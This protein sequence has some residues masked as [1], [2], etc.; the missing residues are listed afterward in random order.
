MNIYEIEKQ[1]LSGKNFAFKTLSAG[2][3]DSYQDQRFIFDG[4]LLIICTNGTAKIIIDYKNYRIDAKSLI[5][6]LP[7]HICSI[8][9]CSNDLEVKMILVSSD[10]MCHL[11]IT[12][13]FNLLKR[14]AIRPYAKLDDGKLDDLLKIGSLINKYDS[15]DKLDGKIQNTLIYSMILMAAS[16]FGDVPSKPDRAI[17]RQETLVRKFFDLLIDSCE[18]ERSVSYYAGKL[19]VSPKYLSSVVK[20]VSNHSAQNW[21]NE[22]VLISAKRHIMTTDMTVYQ[23]ADKLHFQTASS[24]VR[25]FRMHMGCTPLDYKRMNHAL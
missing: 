20:S 8:C 13:D 19:C 11:P 15:D 16:S 18:T 12:P 25:F 24:F 6:I 21:I 22:A 9:D 3:G 17:S 10:F 1:N 23:I 2:L 4:L 5:V 14:I 7:K